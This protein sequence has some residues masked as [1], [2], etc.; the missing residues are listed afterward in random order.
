MRHICGAI[1]SG[2]C[3]R[4]DCALRAQVIS[5]ER[6]KPRVM[7]AQQAQ[8]IGD[9]RGKPRVISSLAAKYPF[10][11]VVSGADIPA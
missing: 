1:E 10:Q 3:P 5:D 6:G 4:D 8:V 2:L 7:I 11:F 9:K